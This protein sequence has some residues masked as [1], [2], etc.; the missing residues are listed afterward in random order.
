MQVKAKVL[1]RS[2]EE[3]ADAERLAREAVETCEKTD[4]LND[5]ASVY[6]DLAEVL[7]IGRTEGAVEA[8]EQAFA[9]YERKE[10]LLMVGPARAC[11]AELQ[12]SG[13]PRSPQP[14]RDAPKRRPGAVS[15]PDGAVPSARDGLRLRRRLTT[16]PA[17][18]NV[19][20]TRVPCG[21]RPWDSIEP[22][23][24]S[25]FSGRLGTVRALRV[26]T[27]SY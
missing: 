7:F 9:R 14:H 4:L 12:P 22:D 5:S 11:L 13:K 25:D 19:G 21:Q 17:S 18:G 26:A 1:A 15:G 2:G 6:A 8:L 27:S 24:R 16:R 20:L 23:S 3:H 10:N